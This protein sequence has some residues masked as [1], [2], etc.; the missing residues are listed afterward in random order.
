MFLQDFTTSM[1][2]EGLKTNGIA[3]YM[4]EIRAL[5]NKAIKMELVDAKY[6]PFLKYKIKTEKTINRALTLDELTAIATVHLDVSCDRRLYHSL[7]LLSFC[8]TGINFADL[9]TLEPENLIN[10]RIIFHRKKTG[11]VYS[12]KIHE[13]A[14]ELFESLQK[15]RGK[16]GNFLLPFVNS[17]DSPIKQKKD[18][19]LIIHATNDNLKVLA[20][21]VNINKPVS[22]Y[23]ARY[24]WANIAR[25]KKRLKSNPEKHRRSQW[26]FIYPSK[27]DNQFTM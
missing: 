25:V 11:K 13:K 3:S 23:Y 22:T 18:I 2:N 16:K 6:Y 19:A 10:D 14:K 4:R 15:R 9:L 5:Y 26:D 12:I 27:W 21:L 7:F 24:S 1:I 8:L 20:S 17:N